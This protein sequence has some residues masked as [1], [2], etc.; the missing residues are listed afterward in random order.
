[1]TVPYVYLFFNSIVVRER[2]LCKC[3]QKLGAQEFY[4]AN[5]RA[6]R[7]TTEISFS[8]KSIIFNSI[9]QHYWFLDIKKSLKI[10]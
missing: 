7:Y 3:A 9:F 5:F 6:V 2:E 10:P 8:L 4:C 1:M